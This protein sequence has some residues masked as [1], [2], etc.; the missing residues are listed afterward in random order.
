MFISQTATAREVMDQ[1]RASRLHAQDVREHD[2][3]LQR[4]KLRNSAVQL[5]E[6]NHRPSTTPANS[7]LPTFKLF[8]AKGFDFV[9]ES[10]EKAGLGNLSE[11]GASTFLQ[12]MKQA[13][14]KP[15]VASREASTGKAAKAVATDWLTKHGLMNKQHGMVD[16]ALHEA[17]AQVVFASREIGEKL[18]LNPVQSQLIGYSLERALEKEGFRVFANHAIDKSVDIF[19]ASASSIATAAG[20]RHSAESTLS[21][22]LNWMASHG[23]TREALKDVLA[24]HSGK[25]SVIAEAAEH[26]EALRRVAHLLSRSDKLVD[27]VLAIS[28]DAELRKSIGTL[29]L[30]AGEDVAHF[31][32]TAGSIAILAGSA[33]RGDSAQDTARHAFRAA[34]SVIGGALGGA[35]GAAVGIAAGGVATPWLSFAGATAGSSMGS[36]VADKVLDLYDQHM[37]KGPH[38]Q[39]NTVSRSD[40][41]QSTGVVAERVVDKLHE[42][43]HRGKLSPDM[44]PRE[45]EMERDYKLAKKFGAI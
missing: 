29:T 17:R 4:E 39:E 45:R 10:G 40:L 34:M 19:K 20:L 33:L 28:K 3:E 44:A 14:A 13:A 43:E 36:Y 9:V 24:K 21:K 6:P 7:T 41:R 11:Q 32:K 8:D 23:V 26:P 35:G 25:I 15:D 30:A 1:F 2:Q 31:N 18:G 12:Q 27:G 16:T 5:R 37:G 42:A 38:V 22:S